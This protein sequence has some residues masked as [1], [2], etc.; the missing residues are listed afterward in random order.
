M[1]SHMALQVSSE[2]QGQNEQRHL[3]TVATE[4]RVEYGVEYT[5]VA[6]EIFSFDTD[7]SVRSYSL[8][9][10]TAATTYF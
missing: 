2:V 4:A 7:K 3:L 10:R 5:E 6:L 1:A 8:F 9:Y